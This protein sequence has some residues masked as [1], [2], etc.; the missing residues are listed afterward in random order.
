MRANTENKSMDM[1]VRDI[2]YILPHYIAQ[3]L[4]ESK[5]EDPD[6]IIF[7]MF[8]SVPHP[9]K[10]GVLIPIEYIPI[11]DPAAVEIAEDG[12]DVPEVTPE[13][14]AALDTQDEA[15]KELKEQVSGIPASHEV[16]GTPEE[17]V[18][19]I[20][21]I[22]KIGTVVKDAKQE[23]PVELQGISPAKASMEQLKKTTDRAPKMPPGGDIGTGHADGLGSRNTR[24]DK[25]I[26]SDLKEEPAVDEDK[27]IPAEIEKP[28]EK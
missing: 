9:R 6:K 21:E 27:E 4:Y 5:N 16:E 1:E 11:T 28:L 3:Y 13:Q 26:A 17:Q 24:L 15:A 14:E 20:K 22:E 7:P 25:K 8:L 10:P 18:A 19:E 23:K 2:N 12:K